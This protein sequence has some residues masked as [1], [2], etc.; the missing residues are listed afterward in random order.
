MKK[1]F[2]FHNGA[3]GGVLSVVRNLLAYS[4][5]PEIENHVIYT[6]NL[7]QRSDFKLPKLEGA[8]TEQIFYFK[9]NWNFYYTCRQ[10]AKLLPDE[11][12]V[13]VA[14]DW[15]ELGM[16]SNLGLQNPVVHFVH[17]AYTYYYELAVKHS[18]WV[19]QYITVAKQISKEL[20]SR[21]PHRVNDIQYFPFPVPTN[22][23]KYEKKIGTIVFAGR[24]EEEKGYQILPSIENILRSRGVIVE[25]HIAGV[26][27]KDEIL[28]KIWP[29]GTNIHFHGEL[30][31][32]DLKNL[33]SRSQIF[34]LPSKAE[35]MPISVIEAMKAGLVPLV[36]DIQG[37]VQEIIINNNTGFR[38]LNNDP[39]S[40]AFHVEN[41]F[42]N[43]SEL[44]RLSNQSLNYSNKHFDPYINCQ[45]N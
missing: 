30:T 12:A 8:V 1:V 22:D 20:H 42:T 41:L 35:G 14:H 11:K 34:I 19:D 43:V 5:D 21:I 32:K 6:I 10:L 15:L 23:S 29:V 37:G 36:N 45:K 18:M 7:E 9:A 27:S 17:G 33:L 13:I 24:C 40:Y 28:Q 39:E 16:V 38:V 3:G 25:W 2:H 44:K 4:Q 31:Q 26:G